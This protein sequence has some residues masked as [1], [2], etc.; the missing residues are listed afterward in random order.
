LKLQFNF[1]KILLKEVFMAFTI[2]DIA[3]IS[4][5]S[6][7]TVDR[8]INN[9]G[10][11]SPASHEK[12]LKVI[13]DL[14]FVPSMAGKILANKR[15][16]VT[17]GA[18]LPS[19][20]NDFFIDVIDGVNK[21]AEEFRDF[22]IRVIIKEI[23]GYDPVAEIKAVEQMKGIGGLVIAPVNNHGLS[24]MLASLNIPVIA[25]NTDIENSGRLCY[26]GHEF[27]KGGETAAGLMNLLTKDANTNVGIVTGFS[28]VLGHQRRISGFCGVIGEKY[29][30]IR[31]V[32]TVETYD[33]D[34]A[35]YNNTKKM[36]ERNPEINALY[37]VAGGVFGA[38]AAAREFGKITV[39]S[40]DDIP[41]TKKLVLDGTIAAT[42]CQEPG[43]Q[44]YQAI[45]VLFDYVVCNK[46]PENE[47]LYTGVIIKIRE[48]I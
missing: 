19:S 37:I 16:T 2:K 13:E 33:D 45:K 46:E 21:A 20:G 12:V 43:K 41:S 34:G 31:V 36:L 4:G 8:V 3:E 28:A 30:N 6:R 9:R 15:K 39:I 5:V 14:G 24:K 48:N 17:F 27:K 40:Y 32:D 11:V 44:G 23:K 1:F 35:A 10:N 29:P 42:I 38:C 47:Y 7:G 22:G 25:V 26:I 18:I